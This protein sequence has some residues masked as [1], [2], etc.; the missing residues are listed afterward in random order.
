MKELEPRTFYSGYQAVF[1]YVSKVIYEPF[2]FAELRFVIG[3]KNS[4]QLL[5]QSDSK[6]KKQ[7]RFGHPRFPAFHALCLFLL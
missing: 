3:P 7:L 4:R 6:L 1:K 2:K 5:I